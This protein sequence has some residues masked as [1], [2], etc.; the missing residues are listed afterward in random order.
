MSPCGRI[1]QSFLF[2]R[3]KTM[4][5]IFLV[6]AVGLIVDSGRVAQLIA[7]LYGYEVWEGC[8]VQVRLLRR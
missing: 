8:D 2:V 1:T 4:E 3:D 7:R 6:L 5:A